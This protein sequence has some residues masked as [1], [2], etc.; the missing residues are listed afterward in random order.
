M[1]LDPTPAARCAVSAAAAEAPPVIGLTL[2]DPC[3][4]GPELWVSILCEELARERKPG[5]PS[6]QLRLYGDAGLLRR[7][8][9][10]LGRS[11]DWEAVCGQ[12]DLVDVTSLAAAES[13][14]GRPS[15]RS[16]AAQLAYLEAAIRAAER[17]E[18]AGLVTAPIH[19]ASAKAAGLGFPGH[20]ELLAARL[21]GDG[22]VVMMLAGPSL[23]VALCTTHLSL[24]AVPQA[25]TVDGIVQV[26]RTTALALH[27]DFAIPA[28]RLFVAGL[29]PHAGESGHFGDEESR[30][31]APAI[32]A[33]LVLPELQELQRRSGLFIEGPLVPDAVFRAAVHPQAG[34]PRPD[35]VVAMYHDQGLIPLKLVDFD[36]A[37]NVSLGLS[38]VRTSPDHGVAHDIAGRG[39]ARPHSQRQA[40]HLCA[41]LLQRRAAA[42]RV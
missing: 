11:A 7:T 18:L 29:N 12:L 16:G 13:E 35:A 14:P 42:R 1:V 32:A 9:Q 8:A 4:I 27:R 31:I 26:L 17:D 39:I 25:L 3:G 2:G 24:A 38:V 41:E 37:V 19:K 30:L 23:R 15:A 21:K 6:P 10:G 20:T 33:A 34:A 5:D 36:A 22:Q 28:P 40:L